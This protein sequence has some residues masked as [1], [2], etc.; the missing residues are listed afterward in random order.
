[1]P[2]Q[3]RPMAIAPSSQVPPSLQQ[4][5]AAVTPTMPYTC[6]TCAKRKVKCDKSGPPCSTCRKGRHE[7]QYEAPAPRKRKRKALDDVHERLE[8]AEDLL[9][10]HGLSVSLEKSSP[11]EVPPSNPTQAPHITSSGSELRTGKLL[12][13]HGKT[14]YIDSTLWHGLSEQEM[15]MSDEEDEASERQQVLAHSTSPATDPVTAAVFTPQTPMRQLVDVHPTYET[16]MKLWQIYV[17]HVEPLTKTFHVASGRAMMQR[18]ASNPGSM[19]KAIECLVFA[20][21]HFAVAAMSEEECLEVTGKPQAV[22]QPRYFDATRQA[23]V[24][25]HFLRTAELMVLHA[26]VIFLLAVRQQYDA[27]TFWIL[28]GVAHRIGQRIGLH[29]NGEELGLKPFDAELRRRLF[30]VMLPLDG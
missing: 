26:Y 23:L 11:R 19:P 18:A 3:H 29:R 17:S 5:E 4:D 2:G 16:A 25:A 13:G 21:Y 27:H 12:A 7:C 22:L 9:R 24:N 6:V 8:R 1:M 14:R 30:W 15:N 10:Q 20:I 28:T